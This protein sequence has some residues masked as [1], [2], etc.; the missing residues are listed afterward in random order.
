MLI[1]HGLEPFLEF[2]CGHLLPYMLRPLLSQPVLHPVI[3]ADTEKITAG[4]A[5][6]PGRCSKTAR[7]FE[8]ARRA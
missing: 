7:G 2:W 8:S 5:F 4:S 1:D 6:F 3:R